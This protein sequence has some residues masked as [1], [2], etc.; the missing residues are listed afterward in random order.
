MKSIGADAKETNSEFSKLQMELLATC[1]KSVATWK[2]ANDD[3]KG[4]ISGGV[5]EIE[6]LSKTMV[7]P[8]PAQVSEVQSVILSFSC[9]CLFYLM[10]VVFVSY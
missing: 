7:E 8:Y 4:K 10:L 1:E 5:E 3:L 2:A 9:Y 6:Q